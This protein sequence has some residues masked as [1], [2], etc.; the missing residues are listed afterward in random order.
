MR[1]IHLSGSLKLSSQHLRRVSTGVFLRNVICEMLIMVWGTTAFAAAEF[2]SSNVHDPAVHELVAPLRLARWTEALSEQLNRSLPTLNSSDGADKNIAIRP[3]LRA[4]NSGESG[5]DALAKR[6]AGGTEA[7][8]RTVLAS[9][10]DALRLTSAATPGAANESTTPWLDRYDSATALPTLGEAELKL[11]FSGLI[12]QAI[13]AN[14]E[15]RQLRAALEAARQ[16]VQEARGQRWP[17]IDVG[18][19]TAALRSG[20]RNSLDTTPNRGAVTLTATTPIYDWGHIEK[21]IDSREKLVQAAEFKYEAA[22][23]KLGY[24][25]LR[26]AGEYIKNRLINEVNLQYVS[27]MRALVRMLQEITVKDRGR[28][29]ELTQARTRLLQAETALDFSQGR[30]M[31]FELVLKKLL[32][33]SVAL[34]QLEK[35][36]DLK[37]A[38]LDSLISQLPFNPTILQ[39]QAEADSTDKQ[40]DALHAAGFPKLN[41]VVSKSTGVDA[42]GYR[43]PW[44]TTLSINWPLSRGGSQDA[45]EQA[46][47]QRAM[48]GREAQQQTQL[49]LEFNVRAADH[50]AKELLARADSYRNL[51]TET[52]RVR[53]DFFEQWYHLGRRTLLDVLIAESEHYGNRASEITSRFDGYL[54]VF[55]QYSE[56]GTL[57]QWITPQS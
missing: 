50:D 45:A 2:E 22:S 14:P 39:A 52:D 29:S 42:L 28:A 15:L 49:D 27:R 34:S 12:Q 47:R 44:Q 19:Q 3:A 38:D 26:N 51:T 16:D 33:T 25:V 1:K 35:E 40:A 43:Q 53:R 32:G 55:R 24:E 41:W 21:T 46:A 54:A 17:Q 6:S 9:P 20:G 11:L 30:A 37:P 5:G 13:E 48:A 10:N 36:W 56:S 4:L 23:G 7:N 8:T 18:T 57:L 31:Q